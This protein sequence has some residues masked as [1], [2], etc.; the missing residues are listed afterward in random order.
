MDPKPQPRID[1]Q[2]CQTL[3]VML[4]EYHLHGAPNAMW[5]ELHAEIGRVFPTVVARLAALEAAA[6]P[7]TSN[8]HNR[9]E[10]CGKPTTSPERFCDTH[11]PKEKNHV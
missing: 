11:E 7:T 4:A 10:I 6:Q 3:V 9:C 2:R 1:V 8:L 5:D